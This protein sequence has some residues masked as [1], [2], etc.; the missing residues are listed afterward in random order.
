VQF[1]NVDFEVL[2]TRIATNITYYRKLTGL[3]QS[4]LAERINYSDKSVS[5]WER[6]ISVPDIFVLTSIAELFGITVNDLLSENAP[7]PQPN[8]KL[9]QKR[10]VIVCLQF[11]A[12][13][14]LLATT[15]FTVFMLAIPDLENIWM[16]F[17][18]AVP[19]SVVVCVVFSAM[20]WRRNAL[21]ISISALAWATAAV[22]YIFI[23]N[24]P[25]AYLIFTICAVAQVGVIL[26]YVQRRLV[27][28]GRRF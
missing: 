8:P 20:W 25:F 12:L 23:R 9:R 11:I 24:L 7:A 13:V 18:I 22:A 2:R 27:E 1:V 15:V 28:K 5:K 3:T 14:W 10:R 16:A 26:I 6:A 21:M 19:A 17:V 4:E